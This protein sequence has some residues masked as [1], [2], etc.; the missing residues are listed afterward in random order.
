[1]PINDIIS[2]ISLFT[3]SGRRDFAAKG[4]ERGLADDAYV[5]DEAY[6]A[7]LDLMPIR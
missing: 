7:T 2:K 5:A 4:V 6:V 1:M 3:I